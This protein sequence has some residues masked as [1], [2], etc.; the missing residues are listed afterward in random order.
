MRKFEKISYEQFQ[1]DICDDLELYNNYELPQRHSSKSAGYDIR[2]LTE[3][4]IKP[5]KSIV[6]R[7]GLKVKMNKD[8]VLYLIGRSSL[9]YK[10]DV[11]LATLGEDHPR[12][13]KIKTLV[14]KL[15]DFYN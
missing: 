14:Y 15:K 5:G 2:S 10:Y 12:T 8:E 6:I 7:T 4:I 3:G 11:C 1:K 13:E 9:G